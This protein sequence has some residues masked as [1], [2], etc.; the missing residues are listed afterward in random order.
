MSCSL[1]RGPRPLGKV[2]LSFVFTFGFGFPV[3]LASFMLK[4]GF[5]T[6][7]E[8]EPCS[9][10]E[11]QNLESKPLL[12]LKSKLFVFRA[13]KRVAENPDENLL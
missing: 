6:K 11:L 8:S 7:F 12:S 13:C 4:K 9:G 10:D 5:G 2:F 1:L 3:V